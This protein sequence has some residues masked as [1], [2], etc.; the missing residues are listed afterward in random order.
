MIVIWAN[1]ETRLQLRLRLQALGGSGAVF[2][3]IAYGA[4][5]YLFCQASGQPRGNNSL[6]AHYQQLACAGGNL[7]AS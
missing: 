5:W 6:D 7:K 1:R 2:K 4:G 3:K